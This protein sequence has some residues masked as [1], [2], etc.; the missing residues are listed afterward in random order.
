M[1][2]S[3]D[4][5]VTSIVTQSYLVCFMIVFFPVN[6]HFLNNDKSYILDF[7]TINTIDPELSFG[8]VKSV[9]CLD[10]FN[11]S[12]TPILTGRI[13]YVG[14]VSQISALECFQTIVIRKS[15]SECVDYRFQNFVEWN[16]VSKNFSRSK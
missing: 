10:F 16:F 15:K 11:W 13:R 2:L 1:N 6:L 7:F 9:F 14:Q 4:I 8:G 12:Q 5:V 3:G